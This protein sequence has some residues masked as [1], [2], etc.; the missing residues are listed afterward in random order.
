MSNKVTAV[1]QARM[2]STR[3]PGKVLRSLG[4]YSIV[5][6]IVFRLRQISAIKK[7][8]LAVPD[9][10]S[11]APL[12]D[13]AKNLEIDSFKGDEEDVLSRFVNACEGT[14]TDHIVRICADN[15]LID[16]NLIA[17]LIAGHLKEKADY[18]IPEDPVPRGTG[19]EVV[20]YESLINIARRATLKPYREHVTAYILDHVDDFKILRVAPPAYLKGREFRLTVDTAEDILLMDE[21]FNRFSEEDSPVFS[22]EPVIQFLEQN[23]QIANRNSHV[24]QK[25]WRQE[26]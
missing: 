12:I 2:G 19:A 8:I 26:K 3:S 11:E 17:S 25:D 20:R 16:P 21:I 5:E 15:P 7:M 6:H 22:L 23:P 13:L 4:H 10:P 18:T 14:G 1:I 9:L 24:L